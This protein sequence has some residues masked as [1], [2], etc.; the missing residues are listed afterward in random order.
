[1][2]E[3]QVQTIVFFDGYCGLCNGVVDFMIDRDHER[4]LRY[5]PLQGETAKTLLS[6]SERTDLDTVIV[7]RRTFESADSPASLKLEKYRKSEAVFVALRELGPTYKTLADLGQVFPEFVRDTVYDLIA[8]NRFTLFGRR[9][10]CRAPS[11]EERTL[12]LP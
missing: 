2:T 1:M 6:E 12:F 3:P 8:K 5:S 11:K 10:T 7:A 9:E 4:R